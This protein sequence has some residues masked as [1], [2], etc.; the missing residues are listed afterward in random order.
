MLFIFI[1]ALF[2]CSLSSQR[3]DSQSD[4]TKFITGVNRSQQADE[5]EED[6]RQEFVSLYLK[7][8]HIDTFF[9]D[10]GVNYK[11]VFRH[12]STM[13]SGLV[14]PAKYNFDTNSDF[15]T[16]NFVSDL[17]VLKEKDTVFNKRVTK[18]IFRPILDT[19]DMPL[20]KY[21]TLLYPT[22]SIDNDSIHIYYSIS[23]PVTDIG[24]RATVNFDKNGNFSIRE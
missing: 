21:A 24:I 14:I 23:I 10:G 13:D 22:L 19:I 9:M 20:E 7:P 6:F 2:S 17:I 15:V 1:L 11:V 16:H 12:F 3:T 5:K 4:T 8:I 18:S